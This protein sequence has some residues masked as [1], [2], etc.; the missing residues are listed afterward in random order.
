VTI[1][2]P[3]SDKAPQQLRQLGDVGRDPPRLIFVSNF[4]DWRDSLSRSVS[5]SS[6]HRSQGTFL[7]H[8]NVY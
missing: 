2:S 4:A 1:K 8:V 5:P 7:I 3:R 6:Q